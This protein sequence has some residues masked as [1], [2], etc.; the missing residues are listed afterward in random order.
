M[1]ENNN[2]V[3]KINV[4]LIFLKLSV[5]IQFQCFVGLNDE[6]LHTLEN[7]EVSSWNSNL[8]NLFFFVFYKTAFWMF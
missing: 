2:T 5:N 7:M 1:Q 4:A 3:T 8:Y 6:I